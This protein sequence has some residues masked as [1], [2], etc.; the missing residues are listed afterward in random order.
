M[1]ERKLPSSRISVF[2]FWNVDFFSTTYTTGSILNI[3]ETHPTNIHSHALKLYRIICRLTAPDAVRSIVFVH[4]FYSLPSFFTVI[5]SW[6]Q[7]RHYS[8]PRRGIAPLVCVA[9]PVFLPSFT[10][11]SEPSGSQEGLTTELF[12]PAPVH[13][14]HPFPLTIK[15][16]PATVN[17]R[18]VVLALPTGRAVGRIYQFHQ[19]FGTSTLSLGPPQYPCGCDRVLGRA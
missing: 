13:R 10:P 12:S 1:V 8:T 11:H 15:P 4:R 19:A 16:E 6:L 14:S 17:L 5:H 2:K 3:A 7:S 9:T 18:P